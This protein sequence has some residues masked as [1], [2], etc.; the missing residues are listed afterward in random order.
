MN[1]R[2][3]R[4]SKLDALLGK[5]PFARCNPLSDMSLPAS[6]VRALLCGSQKNRL[7]WALAPVA[8]LNLP[9]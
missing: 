3:R 6:V 5:L 4:N 8:Y 2:R 9:M 1:E 7:C